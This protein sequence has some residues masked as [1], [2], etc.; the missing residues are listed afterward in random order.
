M[1]WRL[2]RPRPAKA[3]AY[4]EKTNVHHEETYFE[5][6]CTEGCG[7]DVGAA[8]PGRDGSCRHGACSNRGGSQTADRLLLY[9]SRRDHGEHDAWSV[10]GS[11]DAVRLRSQL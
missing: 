6:S 9:S 1:K 7:R 4:E 8:V 10:I 3:G 11:V 2:R 5:K